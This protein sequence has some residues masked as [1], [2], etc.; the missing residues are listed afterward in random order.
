MPMILTKWL[1]FPMMRSLHESRVWNKR[2]YLDMVCIGA[3]PKPPS[4]EEDTERP[5]KKS[6]KSSSGG[7][8]GPSE[9]RGPP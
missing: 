9:P 7:T 1:I 5:R 2:F 6:K 4:H 8:E 3:V